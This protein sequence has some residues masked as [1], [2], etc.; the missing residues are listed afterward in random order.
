MLKRKF[1]KPINLPLLRILFLAL[2]G[3]TISSF[4]LIHFMFPEA[5]F[6]PLE[7]LK[8][9][10]SWDVIWSFLG[11]FLFLFSLAAIGAFGIKNEMNKLTKDYEK[12]TSMEEKI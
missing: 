12:E 7:I 6:N 9:K 2:L 5:T 4:W 11:P 8:Y 3:T 10:I 1:P